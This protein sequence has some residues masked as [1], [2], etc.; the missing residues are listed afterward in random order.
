[1]TDVEATTAEL[2][3]E[4]PDLEDGLKELLD[5]DAAEET[6]TFDDVP[7]DSGTFGELVSRSVVEKREGEYAL[8]DRAAVR[9]ALGVE[10]EADEGRERDT[11]GSAGSIFEDISMPDLRV[12]RPV[13]TLGLVGALALVVLFRVL[14]WPAV[15]RGEDVVLSGND[16]YYYRYLV[17]QIVE[18]SAGPLDFSVFASL[19]SGVSHGEPLIV[20]TLSWVSTLLGGTSAVGGVLAWFPVVSAL[21][22]ALLVYVLSVR[23]TDDR[24]VG[25]AAVALL[26]IMPGH[27][28]RTGLGF[29]DHHAFDYPWLALTTLAV[30]SVVDREE[31]DWRTWAWG[32]ALGVGVAGQTLAW[33]AGPLLLVPL[34]IFVM[35]AVPSWVRA[36]RSPVHEGAVFV[37]G[38]GL[39]T[40]VVLGTHVSWGWHTRV[41]AFA[42]LLL[43]VE[44][45]VIVGLGEAARQFEVS[46][47]PLM[48]IEVLT[49]PSGFAVLWLVFPDFVSELG[50]GID[51]LISKGGVAETM[52]IVSGDLGA[53][54]G[55]IFLF[56]FALFLALPYM[57]WATWQCY[58]G[59]EPEWLVVSIYGW[60]FL[61]L[62]MIQIRFA[63][64]LALF[65]ALFGGLGFVHVAAWVD[66]TMY[67]QPFSGGSNES[68]KHGI[69]TSEDADETDD[70]EW[71]E[72]RRAL[73]LMGFGLGVGSLGIINTPIKHSQ[74]LIDES[75]YEATKFMRE[76]SEER[77]WE[78][79]ENYVF[80][81]WGR[82]RV[83]N[84]FVNGESGSYRYSQ[85]HFT[86]F[87]RSNR[88]E[89]WYQKLI[90]DNKYGFIVV[91]SDNISGGLSESLFNQLYNQGGSRTGHY[92]AI[93][94]TENKNKWIYVPVKGAIVTGK[95]ESRESMT[96][97]K[98]VE[99]NNASFEYQKEPTPTETEWYAT[100]VAYPGEYI[101][102]DGPKEVSTEDISDGNFVSNKGDSAYWPMNSG[103]GDY[104]FDVE[105]GHHGEI[106]SAEWSEGIEQKALRFRGSGG[107]RTDTDDLTFRNGFTVAAWI[108]LTDSSKNWPVV[109]GKGPSPKTGPQEHTFVL[110][111]DRE[112]PFRFSIVAG[113]SIYRLTTD[114]TSQEWHFVGLVYDG[115]QLHAYVDG[116]L[117]GRKIVTGRLKQNDSPVTIGRMGG[118]NSWFGHIDEVRIDEDAWTTEEIQTLYQEKKR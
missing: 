2:L 58:S 65:A 55:P 103:R 47:R 69:S 90:K 85:Q 12:E 114:I 86:D 70:L 35:L 96:I 4:K 73:S 108:T 116:N 94:T 100:R 74:L 89:F 78:Y 56:G 34:G 101:G 109:I 43:L 67:P 60:W 98:Q 87:L 80:S 59:N 45:V 41:V 15:F 40:L 68:E 82:N 113:D 46:A 10:Q 95:A 93:W 102:P 18:A 61:L 7:F 99:I 63:G 25:I 72:R 27:A 21:V 38:L 91:S 112:G 13:A 16:P 49:F 66:L 104:I 11:T 97:R 52:S 31:R 17:H 1:M 29:A 3:A 44:A 117:V 19:P 83:Y 50:R 105:G 8:A 64:Q 9:R 53:I 33:E 20:A 106:Y 48:G 111:N 6:W 79:P 36:S 57:G 92:Q 54:I 24:R 62:S 71:P 77:G 37:G 75:T 42:P 51:F 22:T 115:N 84:W 118:A 39:A 28:F 76:Y 88:D 5:V 30:V 14:P 23:L 110:R 107:I 32:V 81:E 26:A